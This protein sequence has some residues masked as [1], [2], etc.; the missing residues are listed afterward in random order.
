MAGGTG[1]QRCIT[2]AATVTR[3][4]VTEKG[5]P[6]SKA[7]TKRRRETLAD[8]THVEARFREEVQKRLREESIQRI[9]SSRQEGQLLGE[10][11]ILNGERCHVCRSKKLCGGFACGIK[12][13][14]LC[15]GHF[16]AQ[17]GLSMTDD[18]V[19]LLL[20]YCPLCS[21]AC[22]CPRCSRALDVT[23]GHLKRQ[24]LDEDFPVSGIEF[25][26]LFE[27]AAEIFNEAN[28][29]DKPS[30]F[31]RKP[32]SKKRHP[33]FEQV[34][35]VEKVP[36]GDFP[37]EVREGV[38]IDPVSEIAYR[39]IY[40][41]ES[42]TILDVADRPSEERSSPVESVLGDVMEDGSI[43]FCMKCRLFGNLICC[44]FCPRAFHVHCAGVE[45]ED[46][47]KESAWKCPDC[48][49]E[50]VGLPEMEMDGSKSLVVIASVYGGKDSEGV[51][52]LSIIHEMLIRLMDYAFGYVFREPV[53]LK[54]VPAYKKVVK[55][56]MDLG[57]IE[58]KLKGGSYECLDASD[59]LGP[60]IAAVL[61][62]IE[63][64]WHNCYTFN[65]P[66]SAIYRMAEVQERCASRILEMCVYPRLPDVLKNDVSLFK[67]NCVADRKK[68]VF[69]G[70]G[71]GARLVASGVVKAKTGQ[72][73]SKFRNKISVSSKAN[74]VPRKS[75]AVL[76]PD[77]G[78]VVKIFTRMQSACTA[79]EFFLSRKVPCEWDWNLNT[80]YA[81]LRRIVEESAK[82][83]AH[84]LFG[85]RWVSLDDLYGGRVVLTWHKMGEVAETAPHELVTGDGD[86]GG[87]LL[88]SN[89]VEMVLEG[90]SLC[91][92]SVE[93]A[94][95]CLGTDSDRVSARVQ[96]ENLPPNGEFIQFLG[97]KWRCI[98]PPSKGQ[99]DEISGQPGTSGE[100][101]SAV[102]TGGTNG[103]K[104]GVA[105]FIKQELASGKKLASFSCLERAFED[106]LETFKTSN[107]SHEECRDLS[108]FQT[109]YIDGGRSVYGFTWR[110]LAPQESPVSVTE[111][112]KREDC[113][114]GIVDTETTERRSLGEAPQASRW[115]QSRG[116]AKE[117]KIVDL[118]N[119]N[120]TSTF[121]HTVTESKS[122]GERAL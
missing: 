49:K 100:G 64:V 8:G 47:S 51:K 57:T 14:A 1:R 68:I 12:G 50:E 121:L 102:N 16:S 104:G 103:A 29:D 52:T 31:T 10:I 69:S 118:A 77:T 67:H 15:D 38:D 115:P 46:D 22:S 32:P 87:H 72:G 114:G 19:P 70:G 78:R 95:S 101:I 42:T 28:S 106:W 4:S 35:S 43:E 27:Q 6:A 97:R 112:S 76:D 26:G 11:A 30:A 59:W 33:Q 92:N 23:A 116:M 90:Q 13:H 86:S 60:V 56:P 63:L 119:E 65:Y 99:N 58:T 94:I 37:K 21:L 80:S 53:N 17:C 83:T 85:Y 75:I 66:G 113:N 48:R 88:E 18:H 111:N 25:V 73:S 71:G 44:D 81:K 39:T 61:K 45:R 91:F 98:R 107:D 41:P 84:R 7:P 117:S 96:L 9:K 3:S 62:D 93:E 34:R 105:R 122:I 109:E 120:G 89:I 20:E 79:V 110:S 54:Q 2:R 5:G 74:S 82:N 36:V 40:L 55:T 24:Q 108:T